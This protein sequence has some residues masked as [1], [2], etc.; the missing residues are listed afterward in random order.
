MPKFIFARGLQKGGEV[1]FRQEFSEV[2]DL[3]A[4]VPSVS[5]MALTASASSS[6]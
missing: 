3:R 6:V 5:V 1:A 4:L 2:G